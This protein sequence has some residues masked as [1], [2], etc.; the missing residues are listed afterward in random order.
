MG[1]LR[2]ALLRM[3]RRAHRA[4]GQHSFPAPLY[5]TLSRDTRVE[6]TE[7]KGKKSL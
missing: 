4:A 7:K 1:F 5:F 2:S 3:Y 6:Q